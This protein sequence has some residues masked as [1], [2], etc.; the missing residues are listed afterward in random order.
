MKTDSI[1]HVLIEITRRRSNR[2]N[3]NE[4][5]FWIWHLK[6]KT[7]KIIGF[8]NSL[9]D[10]ITVQRHLHIEWTQ[11]LYIF[12]YSI[13]WL[14]DENVIWHPKSYQYVNIISYTIRQVEIWS[15]Q[16]SD[17]FLEIEKKSIFIIVVATF[18]CFT[19][20]KYTY[21]TYS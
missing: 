8:R 12:H 4:K 20:R 17:L 3:Q 10:R 1:I 15:T 5:Y 2:L 11:P 9:L 21:D 18:L 13:V 19:T 14:F 16:E 7:L 6:Y